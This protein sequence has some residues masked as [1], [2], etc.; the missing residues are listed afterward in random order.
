MKK[1]IYLIMKNFPIILEKK[2]YLLLFFRPNL[3]N[4]FQRNSVTYGTPCRA[5]G[6]FVFF[7]LSSCYLQDIMPCKWSSSDFLP[8]VLQI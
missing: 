1:K 8:R 7:L 4:S 2:K 3:K 5:I 6:H